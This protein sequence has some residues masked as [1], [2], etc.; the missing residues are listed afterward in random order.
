MST[1]LVYV[2]NQPMR[3]LCFPA[4]GGGT[5][6]RTW[7]MRSL[8]AGGVVLRWTVNGSPIW[9][10]SR[11][12]GDKT[13]ID[14][15]RAKIAV[16]GSSGLCRQVGGNSVTVIIDRSAPNNWYELDACFRNSPP[17]DLL[18]EIRSMLSTVAITNG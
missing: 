18:T 4:Q 11:V 3:R 10:F 16:G 7:P 1:P 9:R 6:C 12:K 8:D 2:S 14:A 13:S 17:T 5:R 15:H